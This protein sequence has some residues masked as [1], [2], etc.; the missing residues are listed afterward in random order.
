[1]AR[2][3]RNRDWLAAF[4]PGSLDHRRALERAGV[5]DDKSYLRRESELPHDLRIALGRFRFRRL[6]KNRSDALDVA[7]CMP[8]W[9]KNMQITK[10]LLSVRIM[11]VCKREGIK[12]VRDLDRWSHADLIKLKNFGIR[13][14]HDLSD[15]LIEALN[16]GIEQADLPE[17]EAAPPSDGPPP[18]SL[19]EW[20]K[21]TLSRM[22]G[23][24]REILAARI[25]LDGPPK[26]LA[27]IAVGYG[28]TRER[29]RQIER[30]TIDRILKKEPWAAAFRR[31]IGELLDSRQKPLALADLEA[32]DDWFAGTGDRPECLSFLIRA[33]CR[34]RI[35]VAAINGADYAT[36]ARLGSWD[37]MVAKARAVLRDAAAARKTRGKCRKAVARLLPAR[38]R[39]FS[40]MLWAEAS[41]DCH[42]RGDGD[43][44]ILAAYGRD[45]EQYVRFI[46][47]SS[48]V[49]LRADDIAAQALEMSGRR[50]SRGQIRNLAAKSALALGPNLYGLPNHIPLSHDDMRKAARA[51]ERL[52][53]GDPRRKW[54]ASELLAEL[55][56]KHPR[57]GGRLDLYLLSAS[58][59]LKSNL[60]RLGAMVWTGPAP[61]PTR[62]SRPD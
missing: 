38:G 10:M 12:R 25:G 36:R 56:K 17:P 15:G 43:D 9:I 8:P 2:G 14:M 42:F 28:L 45:A 41:L 18:Q 3:K 7:R 52:V 24:D 49:A 44:A 60:T 21:R 48:P 53:G 13:S 16:R 54:H 39:A 51:A 35:V 29:I 26:T 33:L 1:M 23:R 22:D 47:E 57:L 11:N 4:Q 5:I 61:S 62:A 58:L 50:I 37:K 32:A 20:V 59:Q 27:G 30:R 6:L 55:G 31:R 40:D 46:L 19:L 34:N